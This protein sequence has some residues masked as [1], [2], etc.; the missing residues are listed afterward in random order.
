GTRLADVIVAWNVFQHFYPYFDVVKSD[1]TDELPRALEAA[2]TDK[3]ETAFTDT[4]RRLVAALHD[5][6]G[7]V[8]KAASISGSLPLQWDWVDGALVIT[9]VG[10]L[11]LGVVSRGDVV[12]KIAGRPAAEALG[13]AEALISGATPQWIRY[14]GLQ[15]LARGP[16]GKIIS[17]EVESVRDPG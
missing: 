13:A 4:L 16:A 17:L 7:G 8:S 1:W 14:R 12:L 2:A 11:A 15:D 9:E 3:D 6:H 5:G 10:P